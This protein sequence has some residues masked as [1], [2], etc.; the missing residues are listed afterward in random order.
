MTAITVTGRV[1]T[2][3]AEARTITGLLLPYGEEGHTNV[4]KITAAAGAVT[5]P[6]D[7]STVHLNIEHDFTR[8]V[9]RAT[10]ITET[11]EGLVATF[12]VARTRAGDDLLEE[13][14]EGLRAALSVEVDEPVIRAGSLLGGVLSG[15]GAVVRPAFPSA[16]LVAADAGD[17][18]PEET[19]VPEDAAE[20]VADLIENALDVI[21]EN[22]EGDEPDTTEE[23]TM[24]DTATVQAGSLAARRTPVKATAL[25]KGDLFARLAGAHRQGG[26]R[27]MLAALSDIVPANI[28][29]LEQPQYVGELWDGKAYERKIVPLFNQADLTSYE[30]RGWRWVTKPVVAPYAGNKADVPSNP[31][32]TE[33]VTIAAERIAGA[34][35]IDRKFRDFNDEAFFAAYFAAMTESYAKVSDAQVLADVITAAGSA[36]TVGD[37]PTG[38][39]LGMTMIVDGALSVLNETDTM[40]SFAIVASGLW[41]DIVLTREQDKLAFLNAAL[42]LEDGSLTSFRVIPS[43]A[44]TAGQVLVGSR[45]AVT[46]HELP[47][48]P[49]RV[50]AQDIARGGIDEGVFGYY[51]VNVHD[52]DGLVLVDDGVA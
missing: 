46:V 15:A 28:M 6:D 2:A 41:R 7:V 32:A 17:L 4:G 26:E 10:S 36:I 24:G 45:D 20:Q 3:S 27:A 37:A 16:Q 52:A 51:A 1:L 34:H 40:P 5:I 50:E 19:V 43:A 49:I 23:N 21:E 22:T 31:V 33:Q 48:T 35:D 39:G 42:G 11:D 29:G 44:L 13:A 25:T 18:P 12:A 14:A 38:V 8:P 9:G 30:V 47:G